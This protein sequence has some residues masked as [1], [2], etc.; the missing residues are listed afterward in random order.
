MKQRP[1][2][3][4]TNLVNL[5]GLDFETAVQAIGNVSSQGV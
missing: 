5:R 1:C 2:T 4:I 3:V